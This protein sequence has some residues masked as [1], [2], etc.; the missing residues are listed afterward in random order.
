SDLSGKRGRIMGTD[1]EGDQAV[2][3][4]V[5]PMAEV[6]NYQSQLKSVTGGQG[7]FTMQLS[8]YDP[9]PAHVQGQVVAA[10]QPRVEED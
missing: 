7:S 10:Y 5:V 9:V 6:S 3:K 2:I 1:I 8:H 4:A